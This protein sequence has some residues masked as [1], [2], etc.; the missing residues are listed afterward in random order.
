MYKNKAGNSPTKS[1]K[2][3]FHNVKLPKCIHSDL[4]HFHKTENII[5]FFMVSFFVSRSLSIFSRRVDEKK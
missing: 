4:S 3:Y 2:F 5:C 1:A